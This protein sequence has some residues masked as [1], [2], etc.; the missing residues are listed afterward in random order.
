MRSATLPKSVWRQRLAVLAVGA[1]LV[2]FVGFLLHSNYR[3]QVDLQTRAIDRL[4]NEAHESALSVDYFFIERKNDLKNLAESRTLAVYFENQALGMSMTYGLRSSLLAVT[5]DFR[6]IV[7]DRRIGTEPIYQRI[8]FIDAAG[9]LLT[10]TDAGAEVRAADAALPAGTNL[11][12]R[13]PMVIAETSGNRFRLQVVAPYYFKG[14][15][16]GRV[17]GCLTPG[18]VQRC[19]LKANR[20]STRSSVLVSPDS[21][22]CDAPLPGLPGLPE[23][24]HLKSG[25]PRLF[26]SVAPGDGG[27]HNLAVRVPL[28]SCALTLIHA[29]P[30]A[31]VLGEGSPR[32]LVAVM[33]LLALL[34]L[35]GAALT[36]RSSMRNL[37]LRTRLDEASQR[38]QEIE[39]ANRQ[40]R[41]EIAAREQAERE[42]QRAHDRLEERVQ[43]RTA[44]LSNANRDLEQEMCERRRLEAEL[45]HAQKMESVGH[46]AAGIAHEINTPAQ[47]VS[48]NTRFL[49][50]AFSKL[51]D[52]LARYRRSLDTC[53]SGPVPAATW[54]ELEDA[55]RRAKLDYLLGQ[56]P[57]ALSDS[58]EGLERVTQI[59]RA[60]KDFAHPGQPDR[61]PVDL[62]SAIE[63]TVTVAGNEWKYVADVRLDLDPALPRVPCLLGDFNQAMLNLIVNAAHAIADVVERDHGA[64]GTIT[65]TTRCNGDRVEIRVADTGTGIRPEHR[66]KVF[67]HFFTTKAVGKGTGQGL[68]TARRVIVEKHGGTL[69]FETQLGQGTT[70]IIG[71]PLHADPVSAGDRASP[72]PLQ[73]VSL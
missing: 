58:L 30:A 61:V 10:D 15:Y 63:S 47:F 42:L 65:I 38:G 14:S 31:E 56:V 39:E 16:V 18:I 68:T 41:N 28:Q 59:V 21:V 40:L 53:R 46:L 67:D 25:V 60:M 35:I 5:Q 55:A 6:R 70:F 52:L 33:G 57:E 23:L 48:D 44:E 19:L 71:L 29:V 36:L 9:A 24:A 12:D 32:Q 50:D 11:S 34:V 2:G 45:L 1:M 51:T 49:Q 43:Q 17:V 8:A 22:A 66:A 3:S 72:A 27:A 73:E 69:T 13:E 20:V 4:T 64:K 26:E 7:A 54:D 62:N 37:L